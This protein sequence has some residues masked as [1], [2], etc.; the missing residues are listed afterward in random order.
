MSATY[1]YTPVTLRVSPPT[2]P[3]LC[4]LEVDA[5]HQPHEAAELHFQIPLSEA[6]I[7][8]RAE[9]SILQGADRMRSQGFPLVA[10]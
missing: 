7:M 5:R 2:N 1:L 10:F 8:D 6:E 4:D 9:R 3:S